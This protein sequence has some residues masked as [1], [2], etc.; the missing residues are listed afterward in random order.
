MTFRSELAVAKCGM[1]DQR[2]FRVPPRTC[3]ARRLFG[4]ID[5]ARLGY[6]IAVLAVC[7]SDRGTEILTR[8]CQ[9][10]NNSLVH[11]FARSYSPQ[12]LASV[13]DVGDRT[14]ARLAFHY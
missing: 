7:N 8:L 9:P 4:Q 5:S 10:L 11:D 3:D 2:R 12:S 14:L 1:D 6:A 13:R